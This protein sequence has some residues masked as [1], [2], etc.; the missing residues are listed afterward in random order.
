VLTPAE[1]ELVHTLNQVI[2][3]NNLRTVIRVAGGWVRDRLLGEP[4]KN[5][6]DL[7]LE[8]M[9]GLA[10]SRCW[11]EWAKQCSIKD[12]KEKFSMH[13]IQKNPDRSK[14]LETG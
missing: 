2:K 1:K 12:E 4:A 8:S 5:D 10:F 6:V 9:T 13:V 14:H 11:D 3:K 7:A